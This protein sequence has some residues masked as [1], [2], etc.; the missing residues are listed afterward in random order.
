MVM[1]EAVDGQALVAVVVVAL[2]FILVLLLYWWLAQAEA[3]AVAAG[4]AGE[5]E[6]AVG[7]KMEIPQALALRSAW[8]E[9]VQMDKAL[10]VGQEEVMAVAV[11]Q[12]AVDIMEVPVATT[13][14]LIMARAVEQE[15]T[16]MCPW[17]LILLF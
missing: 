2:V 11:E 9:Q 4:I 15:E 5:Q 14:A 16:A 8:Q 17:E 3:E 6:Q 7:D 13:V 12:E 1:P 10:Q